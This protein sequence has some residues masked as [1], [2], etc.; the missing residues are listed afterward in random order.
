MNYAQELAA[1]IVQIDIAP[2]LAFVQAC[3]GTLW[4]AGN[5]GS[6]SIAQHWAC[7]LQK[8]AG[9]RVQA[10]GA[11]SAVLTAWAN[12]TSYSVALAAELRTLAGP[13]DRLICLSCSGTSPN[14]VTVLR[15][16]RGTHLPCALVTGHQ[17]AEG[18]ADLVVTVPHAHSGVIEDC[19]AAI[20]HALT[21]ALC[22]QD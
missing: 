18:A 1:T 11:N 9:R 8:A 15:E 5:G 22:R 20:G 2:L 7:D 19:F 16:A 13:R 14:I 6:A 4:L 10:L 3:Q 17:D 21:E 12:D